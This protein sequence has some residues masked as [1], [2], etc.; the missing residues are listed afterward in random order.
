MVTESRH[1]GGDADDKGTPGT[2]DLPPNEGA[3]GHE[4]DASP[5]EDESAGEHGAERPNEGA[6][7]HEPD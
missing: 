6:P 5:P 2:A 4:I 1:R 7:G 3:A